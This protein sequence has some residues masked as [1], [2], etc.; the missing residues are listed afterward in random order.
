MLTLSL[1]VSDKS[2][3]QLV[4]ISW[5]LS[6]AMAFLKCYILENGSVSVFRLSQMDP[7]DLVFHA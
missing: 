3:S 1:N 2:V 5:T 7:S 6:R 4:I